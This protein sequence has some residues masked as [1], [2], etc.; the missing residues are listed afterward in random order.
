MLL[1]KTSTDASTRACRF[2]SRI[3]MPGR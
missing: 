2:S 1:L 3:H